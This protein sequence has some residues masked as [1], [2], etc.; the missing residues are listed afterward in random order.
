MRLSGF[1]TRPWGIPTLDHRAFAVVWFLAMAS[2]MFKLTSVVVA[3]SFT[4]IARADSEPSIAITTSPLLLIVPLAEV[5][6]EV[7]VADR[8]G[9]SLIAG[10]GSFRDRDTD[11]KISLLEGGASVRYYLTG[12]FRGGLQLGAEAV[13]VYASADSMDIE[14]AGLGLSPFLGY[15]WTHRSGITLEGQLGATVMT[16]RAESDTSTASDSAVG[17]MLN[18]QIGYSF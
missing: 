11:E 1:A 13:Y 6:A 15:K 4:S 9:V 17:P 7:R 18:L 10:V 5:T 3:L 16:A 14:A 12:S 8:V 2:R